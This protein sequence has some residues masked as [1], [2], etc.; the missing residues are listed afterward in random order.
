MRVP[1]VMRCTLRIA[2]VDQ[3]CNGV[4][5]MSDI[6]ES[7]KSKCTFTFSREVLVINDDGEEITVIVKN[8]GVRIS[9]NDDDGGAVFAL[10]VNDMRKLGEGLINLAD[11]YDSALEDPEDE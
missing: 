5:N 4:S 7:K 11:E 10:S 1:Y 3:V 9:V 8:D 6:S 2:S